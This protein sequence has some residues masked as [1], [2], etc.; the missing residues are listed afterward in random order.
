MANG[1]RELAKQIVTGLKNKKN[2]TIKTKMKREGKFS[3]EGAGLKRVT[4]KECRRGMVKDWLGRF[5][6]KMFTDW[7][8]KSTIWEKKGEKT[9]AKQKIKLTSSK[10][11]WFY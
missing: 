11:L 6:R 7:K 10:Q 8:I 2:I 9:S 5:Q 4:R 3:L 1:G